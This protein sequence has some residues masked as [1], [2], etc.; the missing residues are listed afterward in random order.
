MPA[1]PGV[2]TSTL[3]P[4][5]GQGHPMWRTADERFEVSLAQTDETD[6]YSV[7]DGDAVGWEVFEDFDDAQQFIDRQVMSEASLHDRPFISGLD[8]KVARVDV[9]AMFRWARAMAWQAG[10]VD[11][12]RW[13]LI[14]GT[15][16][17]MWKIIHTMPG[18]AK[19]IPWLPYL[20]GSNRQVCDQLMTLG[21][22][23]VM[24]I[25]VAE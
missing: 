6:R 10:I 24:V 22:A 13:V 7:L 14:E 19:D 25:V 11:A 18:Q 20:S 4:I 5:T 23:W 1:P 12:S 9:Q 2:P 16:H 8:E 3:I 21:F 15:E 17:V